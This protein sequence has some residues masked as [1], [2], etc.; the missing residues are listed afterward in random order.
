MCLPLIPGLSRNAKEVSRIRIR[1]VIDILERIEK[2]HGPLT[3]TLYD[4]EHD[5]IVEIE[6]ESFIV[7]EFVNESIV[8]LIPTRHSVLFVHAAIDAN[9][10]YDQDREEDN[11]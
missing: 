6:Q 10:L 3:V 11:N 9:E 4:G 1:E 2:V 7:H 8:E 5:D